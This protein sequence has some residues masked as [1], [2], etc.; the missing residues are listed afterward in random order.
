MIKAKSIE[1]GTIQFTCSNGVEAI[2]L[3]DFKKIKTFKDGKLIEEFPSEGMKV[4]E[5]CDKF[6]SYSF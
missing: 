5:L 1:K 3:T 6:E 4:S 2:F